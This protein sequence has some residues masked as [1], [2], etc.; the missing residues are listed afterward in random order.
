MSDTLPDLG[1]RRAIPVLPLLLL[2]LALLDLRVE[3]M[4]LWDHL[5]LTSLTEAVRNHPLAVVVLVVQ[6]SLWRRY[7]RPRP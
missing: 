1:G 5:T 3:L 2:L 6:P 7:R 4:L